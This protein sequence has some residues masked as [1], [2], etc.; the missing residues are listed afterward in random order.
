MTAFLRQ[1]QRV[2][3]FIGASI[4]LATFILREVVRDH[5]KD[6]K[7]SLDQARNIY[8][9]RAQLTTANKRVNHLQNHLDQQDA[10]RFLK[11]K[12]EDKANTDQSLFD[13]MNVTALST[14]DQDIPE[15][16]DLQFAQDNLNRF[17]GKLPSR[18]YPEQLSE[19]AEQLPKLKEQRNKLEL[20]MDVCENVRAPNDRCS[21]DFLETMDKKSD[22][23]DIKLMLMRIDLDKISIPVLEDAERELARRERW[24]KYANIASIFLFVGGW[25]LSLIGT[26]YHVP[27]LASEKS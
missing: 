5:L 9:I 26:L 8:A 10:L 25:L 2:V 19:I 15:V 12:K 4:V 13:E 14:I 16:E 27:T 17:L 18:E 11:E 20:A 21:L 23:L 24:Y 22:E 6:L 1:H 7:D 3:T